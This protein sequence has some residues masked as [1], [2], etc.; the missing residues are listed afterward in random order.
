[1]T[2]VIKTLEKLH[3]ELQ[4]ICNRYIYQPCTERTMYA[5]ENDCNRVIGE[6]NN[7]FERYNIKAVL[8]CQIVDTEI[9][10]GID[11]IDIKTGKKVN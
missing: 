8:N 4:E 5:F 7:V 11:L 10:G 1:M 9:H 2:E 6:A 3:S